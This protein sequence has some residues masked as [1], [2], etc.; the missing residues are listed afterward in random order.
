MTSKGAS[1]VNKWTSTGSLKRHAPQRISSDLG[2]LAAVLV[3]GG[4]ASLHQGNRQDI[5][6]Y[7]RPRRRQCCLETPASKDLSRELMKSSSR[8]TGGVES[9]FDDA[10]SQRSG[11]VTMRRVVAQRR[12]RDL[13][14][15]FDDI[16]LVFNSLSPRYFI[17]R[18]AGRLLGIG[19]FVNL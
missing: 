16:I 12:N 18:K 1:V 13:L 17:Q 14:T 8:D 5:S 15:N 4:I 11:E 3:S 6:Q 2:R 10:G 7:V 9:G 19:S